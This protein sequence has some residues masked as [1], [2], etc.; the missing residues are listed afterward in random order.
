MS[1]VSEHREYFVIKWHRGLL[2]LF[3]R[4]VELLQLLFVAL[5]P[6]AFLYHC[7]NVNRYFV[8]NCMFSLAHTTQV[9]FLSSFSFL[10]FI[11]FVFFYSLLSF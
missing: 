5:H 10:P 6:E 8:I 1:I 2:K 7:Y 4:K 11:F 9:L 3:A